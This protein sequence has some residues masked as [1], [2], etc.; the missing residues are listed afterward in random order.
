[1]PMNPGMYSSDKDDWGTPQWLFDRVDNVFHF[2]IDVCASAWNAKCETWIGE[3]YNAL[4]H[5]WQDRI[6]HQPIMGWMNPPYG[7]SIANWISKLYLEWEQGAQFVAL[8]PARTDTL[9]FQ[10]YLHAAWGILF[11]KGRLRY[12]YRCADPG[13]DEIT[14][15]LYGPGRGKTVPFCLRHG[16]ALG[17]D[18]KRR[19][20][21]AP[22]PSCLAFFLHH[23]REPSM[24]QIL[25]LQDLGAIYHSRALHEVVNPT[26]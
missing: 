14:L 20:S 16:D 4:L 7:R 25:T 23:D 26:T 15:W 21:T 2:N 5:T 1:M 18:V 6:S 13:C 9:W 8:L 12:E 19:R 22:F 24:E 3:D 17:E 10:Y 11:L